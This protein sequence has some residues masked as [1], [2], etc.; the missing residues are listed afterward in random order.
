[1]PSMK[2]ILRAPFVILLEIWRISIG[3]LFRVAELVGQLF[4]PS[5]LGCRIRGAIYRP[6]LKSCGGNFQVGLACKLEHLDGIEV[7]NDVYVG[8]GCWLSGLRGGIVL[9]DEVMFG[10][11]VT[12]VSSNHQFESGSARFAPGRPGRIEVGRGSWIAAQSTVI[13]GSKI[14][15]SC[16]VAAGAVVNQDIEDHAIV[17]GVPARVMG[18]T[19]DS[20]LSSAGDTAA[21]VASK[22]G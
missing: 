8:H 17:G 22:S 4:P 2:R 5:A 20:D 9:H 10:P 1:M 11:F 13:A 12:M 6:F 18:S 19:T 16:L 3:V 15:A 21:H 14:G 7:G